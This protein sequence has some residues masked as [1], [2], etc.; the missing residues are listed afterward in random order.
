MK[1]RKRVSGD[2]V[3]SFGQFCFDKRIKWQQAVMLICILLS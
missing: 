2:A 1:H 3:L